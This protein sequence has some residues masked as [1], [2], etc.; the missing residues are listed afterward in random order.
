[1]ASLEVRPMKCPKCNTDT[2][3]PFGMIEGVHVDFCG[4]CKGIWFDEGELA[5]YTEMPVDVPS[6]T[7]DVGT[8]RDTGLD[9]PH[10]GSVH[11]VEVHYLKGQHP[12]LDV[13]PKCK[14]VFVDK[15]ELPQIES[16][17][18]KCRGANVI[19]LVAKKLEAQGYQ[20]LGVRKA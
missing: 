5:F 6:L 2:L 3:N 19:G 13:C 20:I 12:L 18:V 16:L 8:G 10:C 11:L 1:M 9:C 14:G 7:Q 15:G 4:G 17:S